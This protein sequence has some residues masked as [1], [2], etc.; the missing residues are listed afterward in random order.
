LCYVWC[1]TRLTAYRDK[2]LSVITVVFV[3][4]FKRSAAS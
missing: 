4:R 1:L 2:K 3:R